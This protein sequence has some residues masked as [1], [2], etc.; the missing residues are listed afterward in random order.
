MVVFPWSCHFPF[1]TNV[2]NQAATIARAWEELT[3]QWG[4]AMEY[5]I[6][7]SIVKEARG[8]Q[9]RNAGTCAC[10]SRKWTMGWL[11][12]FTALFRLIIRRHHPHHK[13]P[14]TLEAFDMRLRVVKFDV[15][16]LIVPKPIRNNV[17]YILCERW[18]PTTAL[19]KRKKQPNLKYWTTKQ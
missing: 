11:K 5:C 16:W 7:H 10:M 18:M 19:Q 12:N 9:P 1:P 4:E 6:H 15:I 2:Q 8:N 14:A 17:A 3:G 13:V